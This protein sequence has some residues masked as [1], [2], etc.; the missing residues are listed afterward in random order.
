VLY[1]LELIWWGIGY[2]VAR[3]ILPIV[4]FGKVRVR[5]PESY[6]EES[7]WLGYRRNGS[8]Q[9]EID[10]TPACGIG[11]VICCVG[12]AIVLHFIH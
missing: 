4:S 5:P 8:G 7:S 3:L 11:M 12:L 2:G 10:S 9:F 1:F 6:Y